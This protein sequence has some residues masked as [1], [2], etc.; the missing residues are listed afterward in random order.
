[1]VA[2]GVGCGRGAGVWGC[3]GGTIA[4]AWVSSL[5]SSVPNCTVSQ[6][7]TCELGFVAV[8]ERSL[9]TALYANI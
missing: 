3:G 2:A 9:W 1:M 5:E 7:R 6:T 8:F 4:D